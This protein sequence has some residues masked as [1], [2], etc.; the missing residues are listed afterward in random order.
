[1]TIRIKI[2]TIL[3]SEIE[4][5]SAQLKHFKMDA[6]GGAAVAVLM[7]KVIKALVGIIDELGPRY[8]N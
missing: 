4:G 1:M 8:V 2:T 5:L 6:E 3:K 7:N